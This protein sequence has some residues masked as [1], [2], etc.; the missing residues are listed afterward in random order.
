ML[1]KGTMDSEVITAEVDEDKCIG[2]GLC[3]R[4]CPYGAPIVE[5]GKAKV[6]KVLCKG[7][8]LCAAGCP[9]MAI[10]IRHFTD[11]QIVVQLEAMLT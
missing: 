1:S 9:A 8:G 6:L 2:C 4:L 10:T 11:E 5:E 7:C 3:T